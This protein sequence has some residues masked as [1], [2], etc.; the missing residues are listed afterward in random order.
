M[1]G[2]A[3]EQFVRA[4]DVALDRSSLSSATRARYLRDVAGF[5]A[6]LAA[7]GRDC[8]GATPIDVA[9]ILAAEFDRLRGAGRGAAKIERMASAIGA[10]YRS[11]GLSDPTSG[12]MV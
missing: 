2:D 10:A 4:V 8:A 6:S 3:A 9:R 5:A 11:V 1:S 7:S 12:L